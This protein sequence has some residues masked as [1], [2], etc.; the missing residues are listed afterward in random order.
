MFL[1]EQDETSEKS[2][3]N[4]ASSTFWSPQVFILKML[5]I[6]PLDLQQLEETTSPAKIYCCAVFTVVTESERARCEKAKRSRPWRQPSDCPNFE[7]MV[8]RVLWAKF[9]R[10]RL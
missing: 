2:H 4:K 3:W 9:K 5:R 8:S 10:G 7:P 6:V 1:F